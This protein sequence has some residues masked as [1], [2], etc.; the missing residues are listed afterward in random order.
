MLEA[1]GKVDVTAE[2]KEMILAGNAAK[3]LKLRPV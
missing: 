2:E 1:I 3:L